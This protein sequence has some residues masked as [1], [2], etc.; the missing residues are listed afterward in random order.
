MRSVSP[1]PEE[2]RKNP[3]RAPRFI[4]AIVMGGALI[5]AAAGTVRAAPPVPAV[6]PVYFDH[7]TMR[8]GLSESS[9]QGILQDSQE[10]VW[11]TTESGLNRYDGYSVRVYRRERG[12]PGALP[13][14]SIWTVAEDQQHDLWLA[15]I[16]GG[17]VRWR[18]ATDQFQ[19][20]AHDPSRA[21]SLASDDVRTLL[22]DTDGRIW[23]GTLGGGLDLF[24]PRT[25][26][27][28]HFRHHDD[29][30]H[31][32]PAD[33]VYALYK[34]R[35]GHMW[36]GTD[37][38]LSRYQPSTADFA[39]FGTSRDGLGLSDLQ[40][41]A[42]SE[43]HTG[44]LWIG[45]LKGGLDRLDPQ[46][47]R[48]T[49]FRHDSGNSRSL[50]ND[51]VTAIL[52]DGAE[53]L[54]V[55]TADGLNL[56]D[57]TAENFVHY[58]RDPDNP[59]SLRDNNVIALYQDRGGVL[60]VGTRSSGASHWNPS[61]WRLGHYRSAALTNTLVVS[62][63][64]DGAG[65]VWVGTQGN[66]LI[67][68]DAR[69]GEERRYGTQT[70]PLRLTDDR[71]MALLYDSRK[72]L[73]VGTMGGGLNRIDFVS[74]KVSVWRSSSDPQSLPADGVMALYQDPRG[75][76]WVGTFGGGV[77]SIDPISG[78]VT[79]YPY[80]SDAADALSDPRASA[81]AEDSSGNL[82]IGTA[83]GGLNLFDRASGHFYHYRRD[84]RDPRSLSD[85]VIFALHVDR[86]DRVWVGTA[87]GGL[88]RVTGSSAAPQAVRFENF[89]HLL[90]SREI[91]GIE[92]D[93]EDRLWVSTANGIAR[94]DPRTRAV[95]SFHEWDGLQSEDFDSNAY[96][97]DGEGTLYF[98]GNNGFNAFSPE[99]LDTAAPA[100]KV[101]LTTVAILNQA[102]PERDLPGPGH[103]LRL[104][105]DDRLVT[106]DFAALDFTA[107]ANNH[108]SYRLDGFDSAWVDV[109][110]A[111]RATYTNLDS[112]RYVFRVRAAN[113]E[114]SWSPN[115]LRFPVQ[116]GSAPWNT[117]AARLA[118]LIVALA[119]LALLWR[120]WMARRET[121]ARIHRLA[122]FDA[123][124]ALPNREW[125][126][127]YLAQSLTEAAKGKNN[128]ALLFIDLDQF[129]RINDTLGHETGDALLHQVAERLSGALSEREADKLKIRVRCQLARVGGDEF[130]LVL[131][132]EPTVADAEQVALRIQSAL[133][134]PFQQ[135]GFELIVTP[136][137][138][139]ALYP[140][141]GTDAQTLLKN[142]DGAMYEAKASGRNQFRLYTSA[143]NARAAKRLSL[144]M[145]LRRAFENEQLEV[146]Y[147][148][149]YEARTL[150]LAGG[151][152][153]LRW[154]H[155]QRGQI[156]TG[157]FVAVAEETGLISDIDRWALQRVCRDVRHWRE[158]GLAM[159]AISVNVSGRDF[160]RR[161][162]VLRISKILEEAH[163]PAS[164][165]ELELTES[166]LMQDLEN[167]QRTLQALK[168]FGFALAM[169][170]FGT[171]YCSLN[172][173]KR[174]PLD[175]LK[176]DQAFVSDTTVDADNAAIVRAIIGLGHHLSLKLVAEG[177]E[178][179][180]QLRFLRTEGCD[181]VQGFLMSEAMSAGAFRALLSGARSAEAL[182]LEPIGSV[183][184]TPR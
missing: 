47:G 184:S 134:S 153:L 33:R 92:S 68:I 46:S 83:G 62:F 121:Q 31:S 116:V 6:R 69:I 141:H 66:G 5:A 140:E 106:F 75:T 17:L 45:T 65:R 95:R 23:A 143:V 149:Q 129:K 51:R 145:E 130:I 2:E 119:L 87:N 96:Y 26:T 9:V 90:P 137:I 173:L 180:E 155:P 98:G 151:E 148:P 15:T 99:T 138:G 84:D 19:Q 97:R 58:G 88:D 102:L 165:F 181:L 78:V 120:W 63:A 1:L 43:D 24:D 112:G 42:I 16:G 14:D 169:D 55:A 147:Q 50:S 61:S 123:L 100:P 114:G 41:R 8:D 158:G 170:D 64:A 77:A 44:V 73:W 93:R 142:A 59:H 82:W 3:R 108:Y 110:A 131:T 118:Y 122:Y 74:G 57:R 103:A 162:V 76:I 128:L 52:E 12:M 48:I 154:F 150:A 152:A 89:A 11:L 135:A 72:N 91:D 157:D 115:E 54:W 34:D 18:R 86:Q 125:I 70:R 49:V 56:F 133:A 183:A 144:E 174:F 36:V 126:G 124:T 127:N 37:A 71:I 60:W 30:P 27:A 167:G 105:Y 81:F 177:V 178:T 40:V 175:T 94:L 163:L 182:P 179:A 104:A 101:V 53:R 32:L 156:P 168:E 136:S 164:L 28:R 85:N 117:S 80:G 166:V 172:Y 111:H 79:R 113:A 7:L 159:P 132:G 146:Y 10:Y 21:D 109:G 160:M 4:G 176:I 29:D 22:V 67:E 38:G 35:A 25:G 20:F 139:I 171:G 161:D 13:S 107:P 39:N